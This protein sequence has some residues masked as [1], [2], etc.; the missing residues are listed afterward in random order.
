V[1]AESNEAVNNLFRKICEAGIEQKMV[2]RLGNTEK[3]PDVVQ[4][5]SFEERYLE[6]ANTKQRQHFDSK[7]AQE[8]LDNYQVQNIFW[9]VCII[10]FCRM[11]KV[12]LNHF[13]GRT[14][15]TF[16]D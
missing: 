14:I 2:L 4:R 10:S 9:Y 1:T 13:V 11:L 16:R 15:S 7:L 8:I 12:R 6:K 3:M 5:G